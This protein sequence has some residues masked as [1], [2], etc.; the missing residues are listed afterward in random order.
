MGGRLP[1]GTA[2][3]RFPG[4]RLDLGQRCPCPPI[5]QFASS[6]FPS[7]RPKAPSHLCGAEVL[8]RSFPVFVWVW[9]ACWEETVRGTTVAPP[10]HPRDASASVWPHPCPARSKQPGP[11]SP[12]RPTAPPGRACRGLNVS[13][14]RAADCSARVCRRLASSRVRA[15]APLSWGPGVSPAPT[16]PFISLF[17]SPALRSFAHFLSLGHTALDAN[18]W[19]PQAVAGGSITSA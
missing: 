15:G 13:A 10:P 12:R 9:C 3:S 17:A 8:G 6:M 18:P 4:P 5:S 19:S 11:H 7:R 2:A 14:P 16:L 1:L